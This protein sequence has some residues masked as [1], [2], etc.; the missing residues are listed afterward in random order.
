M[1]DRRCETCDH[2]RWCTPQN[3]SIVRGHEKVFECHAASPDVRD[4]SCLGAWPIVDRKASCGD[5]A[6]DRATAEKF[7]ADN[8][9]NNRGYSTPEAQLEHLIP[10]SPELISS[11]NRAMSEYM[12]F[13]ENLE[14][15]QIASGCGRPTFEEAMR[16]LEGLSASPEPD[17]FA[18]ATIT[19][20]D[21]VNVLHGWSIMISAEEERAAVVVC[22]TDICMAMRNAGTAK[23]QDLL[24]H[25]HLPG[26]ALA[27]KH[28]AECGGPIEREEV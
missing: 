6:M 13:K 16:T 2:V 11:D 9:A 24:F 17:L 10:A 14:T 4:S 5:Y 21:V 22:A 28:C 19:V 7:H 26:K 3:S 8:A 20:D 25:T 18:E 12:R 27:P 15:L 23:L 1:D